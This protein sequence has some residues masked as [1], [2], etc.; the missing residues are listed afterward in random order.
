VAMD[1]SLTIG[2]LVLLPP[3]AVAKTTSGKVQRAACRKGLLEGTLAVLAE[4]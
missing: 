4:G 1:H 3:G 2:R